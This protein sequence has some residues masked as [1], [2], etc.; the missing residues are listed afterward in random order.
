MGPGA[1]SRPL[2]IDM[3]SEMVPE[4]RFVREAM[5]AGRADAGEIGRIGGESCLGWSRRGVGQGWGWGRRGG[6]GS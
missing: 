3:P 5:S 2:D 1:V 4:P 6:E